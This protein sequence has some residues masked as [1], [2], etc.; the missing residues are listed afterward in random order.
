MTFLKYDSDFNFIFGKVADLFIL[1]VLFLL[2]CVPII[3]IGPAYSA[4]YHGIVSLKED[5][6]SN[7]VKDFFKAFKNNLKYSILSQVI[8]VVLSVILWG[9]FL[10]I[11]S[12]NSA[13]KILFLVMLG[14][15]FIALTTF[16][17]YIYATICRCNMKFSNLIKLI[18]VLAIKNPL[19]TFLL[20]FINLLPLIIML[21]YP[22]FNIFVIFAMTI[23][24]FSLITLISSVILEKIFKVNGNLIDILS[25]NE[26]I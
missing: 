17:V 7:L 10:I 6:I 2:C 5:S 24:G 25:K 8:I 1:N 11:L 21:I 20:I 12:L 26:S 3:T 15:Y 4:L 16:A 13:I 18:F 23:L 9:N 19:N 14:I 22:P